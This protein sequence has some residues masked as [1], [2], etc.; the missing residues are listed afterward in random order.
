MWPAP[1][2]FAETDDARRVGARLRTRRRRPGARAVSGLFARRVLAVRRRRRFGGA[3]GARRHRSH[4]RCATAAWRSSRAST[5]SGSGSSAIRSAPWSAPRCWWRS[6]TC[7]SGVQNVPPGSIVGDARP[8]AGVPPTRRRLF[9]PAFGVEGTFDEV[10]RHLLFDP[11][12][13]LSRW[14]LEPIDP[15]A[16][17]PYL[18]LDPVRRAVR[19]RSCFRSPRS[20]RSRRALATQSMLAATGATRM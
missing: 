15:L 7:A 18:L 19:R 20:T 9:L 10:D 11:V 5:R 12:I 8:V 1:D 17:A 6:P 13:D 16:L 2:G 4:R 3:R 14:I